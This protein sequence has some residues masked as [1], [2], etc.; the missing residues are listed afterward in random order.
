L[1]YKVKNYESGKYEGGQTCAVLGMVN[2]ATCC[3]A[4]SGTCA[5]KIFSLI[6]SVIFSIISILSQILQLGY[7]ASPY[8]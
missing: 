5:G 8:H 7:Q 3:A 6:V 1:I 4:D 2:C